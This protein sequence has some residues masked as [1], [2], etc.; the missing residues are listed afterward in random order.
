MKQPLRTSGDPNM[1]RMLKS[2][3]ARRTQV[4]IIHDKF[5]LP[6]R[7]GGELFAVSFGLDELFELSSLIA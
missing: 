6:S 5:A 4:N 2:R 3:S 7:H 1:T